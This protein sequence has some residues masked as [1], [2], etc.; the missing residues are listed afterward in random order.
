MR[1]TPLTLADHVIEK[2]PGAVP[3]DG[4]AQSMGLPANEPESFPFL[5]VTAPVVETQSLSLPLKVVEVTPPA[6]VRGIEKWILAVNVHVTAPGAAPTNL[7]GLGVEAYDAVA[8]VPAPTVATT[9]VTANL[10]RQ[11]CTGIPRSLL[12]AVGH[13]PPVFLIPTPQAHPRPSS[14]VMNSCPDLGRPRYKAPSVAM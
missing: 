5:T 8:N 9:T 14:I 4:P 11:R 10:R 12:G 6:L 7:G 2:S 13:W 3:L 1:T